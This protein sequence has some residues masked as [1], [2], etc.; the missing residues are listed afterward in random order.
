MFPVALNAESSGGRVGKESFGAD[1]A[2]L[3]AAGAGAAVVATSTA[4]LKENCL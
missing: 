3:G 2:G 4:G 1:A